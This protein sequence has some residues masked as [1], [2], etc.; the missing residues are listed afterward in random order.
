MALVYTCFI[1]SFFL[2]NCP[3]EES[4]DDAQEESDNETVAEGDN[5]VDP[6]SCAPTGWIF[7]MSG[8]LILFL[9]CMIA[10]EVYEMTLGIKAYVK[11]TL[12]IGWWFM[13][14]SVT[15]NILPVYIHVQGHWQYIVAAVR[16]TPEQLIGS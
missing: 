10:N 7:T 12:N 3:Y 8:F 15:L 11:N 13:I 2:Y 1:V 5:K 14:V 6:D 4:L 9:I 16:D